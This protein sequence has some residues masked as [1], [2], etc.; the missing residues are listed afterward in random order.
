MSDRRHLIAIGEAGAAAY[1][2]ECAPRPRSYRDRQC[3]MPWTG[4]ADQAHPP[5]PFQN[6]GLGALSSVTYGA[7]CGNPSGG[8]FPPAL[9]HWDFRGPQRFNRISAVAQAR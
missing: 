3:R 1:Y 8:A 6:G 4:G 5:P 2:P 9:A 7:A